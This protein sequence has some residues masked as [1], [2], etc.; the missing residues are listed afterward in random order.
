MMG[1]LTAALAI[2]LTLAA[3]AKHTAALDERTTLLGVR[4]PGVPQWVFSTAD[5]ALAVL[6][7]VPQ[8]RSVGAIL[9]LTMIGASMVLQSTN[10]KPGLNCGCFGAPRSG[11]SEN[12]ELWAKLLLAAEALS[13]VAAPRYL[14]APRLP[15]I[16]A[17][18]GLL[19]VAGFVWLQPQVLLGLRRGRF[20]SSEDALG[21]LA[22]DAGF[23]TWRHHLLSR[24]PQSVTFD[25]RE[26][27]MTFDALYNE[28][29]IILIARVRP[30]R[31]RLEA[32]DGETL[33]PAMSVDAQRS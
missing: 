23:A 14:S 24:T 1:A 11:D 19:L 2:Q 33:M 31:V 32:I 8:S 16:S 12:R 20:S 7:L 25:G 13:M 10:T 30:G 26:H 3:A 29:V 21:E 18:V 28:R 9:I 17:C 15:I 27:R 6:V 4:W 22:I 5:V